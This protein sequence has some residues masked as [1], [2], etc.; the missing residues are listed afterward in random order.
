MFFLLLLKKVK[1][2]KRLFYRLQKIEEKKA[3]GQQQLKI[4]KS[5]SAFNEINVS[6]IMV[7]RK[8]IFAFPINITKGEILNSLQDH[9]Y[10]RIPVYKDNLDKIIGFV[11]IK[12]IL[13]NVNNIFR[14]RDIVRN[15][16]F[17]PA[18]MKAVD[19]LVKMQ[20]SH[21]HVA[22]VLDEYGGTEGLVTIVNIIEEIVGNIDDEHDQNIQPALIKVADGKFEV[23]GS[24]QI[25]TLGSA[26]NIQF[27]DNQEY[28]TVSGLINTLIGRIP[29][30]GEVIKDGKITYTITEADERCIYK[31]I[32]NI[33]KNA[34]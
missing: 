15:I 9:Q 22:I 31:V 21:I 26:L 33:G 14:I 27:N 10:T 25:A 11:H 4:V 28:D 19:L 3:K 30:K 13:R 7:T 8:E 16:I 23:E 1:K 32:I 24:M 34:T 17:V 20:S 29:E 2:V 6:D 12:D 5:L 18:A